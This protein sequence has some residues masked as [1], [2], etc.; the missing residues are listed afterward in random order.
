MISLHGGIDDCVGDYAE[1]LV[2]ESSFPIITIVLDTY[3]GFH[4]D[5]RS[6]LDIL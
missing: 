4:R 3:A 2:F 1:L 6:M 5:V